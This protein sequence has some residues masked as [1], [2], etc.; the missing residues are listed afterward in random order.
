MSS[1]LLSCDK[2]SANYGD[3]EAVKQVSLEF[4][5]GELVSL[6]GAN[7]S[8]KSTL[9][10][11]LLGLI[12]PKTGK[13]LVAGKNIAS[14]KEQELAS[15][16][17][18]V[19]QVYGFSFGY[20]VIEVVLMG[21]MAGKSIFAQPNLQDKEKAEFWLAR[22]GLE[23]LADKNFN[24]LSGGQRQL[25]LIARA[26]AQE[27]RLILLDEPTNGLDF[28][29]QHRLLGLLQENSGAEQGIVFS[30]HDPEHAKHYSNR[31]VLMKD[32]ELVGD[33]NPQELLDLAGLHKI[34]NLAGVR[35]PN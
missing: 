15:Y 12:K 13:V 8:G 23:N 35:L 26:L 20:P 21:V 31:S 25:V 18:Y 9:I 1:S 6:V 4:N 28:A 33:G 5:P 24:E 34:Y 14:Y 30:T 16:L 32:G 22:L 19:P 11:S 3:K 17:A 2:L 27:A 10:K 7:G 29:N